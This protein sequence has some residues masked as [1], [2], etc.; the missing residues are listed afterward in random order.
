MTVAPELKSPP[1]NHQHPRVAP[2]TRRRPIHLG[3]SVVF[4]LLLTYLAIVVYPVFWLMATSLKADQEIFLHPFKLP[5][6]HSLR[7]GNFAHA[8]TQGYLGKYFVNSVTLTLGSVI[9]TLFLAATTAF[10]VSRYR[11]RLA[12]PMLLFFT[13]GLMVPL[14]LTIVPMFFQMRQWHL[15]DSLFGLFLAYVG[16][17]L[18]FAVFVLAGFFKT[19]SRSL[20]EAAR[21]DGCSEWQVFWHV[22]L[23]IG[24]PGLITVAIFLLLGNWNEFLVAFICLSGKGSE[25]IRTLPLGLANITIVSQYHSDWGMAF[26]GLVLVMLPTVVAYVFLQKHLTTGITAGAVKG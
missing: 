8:W 3:K 26:A 5:D 20:H 6:L 10:A 4:L 16:L 22:I 25:S 1:V 19:I 17:G 21:L 7:W 23:P 11:F 12:R 13:A 14:Q 24:R 15:L 2:S 9:V 18:P